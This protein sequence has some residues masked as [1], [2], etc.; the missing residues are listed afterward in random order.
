MLRLQCDSELLSKDL[1]GRCIVITGATSGVG[2]ATALQL[3]KQ[4]AHVVVACR[5]IKLGNALVVRAKAQCRGSAEALL[6]DVSSLESVRSFAAALKER[7]AIVHC[8]VNNAGVMK[9]PLGKTVDGFEVHIGT[10][11][12]G[13][14]L[15]TALLL[16]L[17][18][19]SG[20][21]RVV[22]VSSANH[23]VFA[24]QRGHIDLDDLHYERRK[25]N[26][27]AG[28]AQSKLAQ[29]L[30][31]R[32][33][34][35]RRPSIT[36]VSL[37]P[38]SICTNVTRHMMS[39]TMRR[40]ILPLERVLVGQVSER[41]GIQTGLHCILSDKERLK[42]GAY[43]SQN[44]SPWG[45]KGG[46]PVTSG[47]PEASDDELSHKLWLLSASLVGLPVDFA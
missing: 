19:K 17:L 30:H 5:N 27:W 37:H 6:C 21:G 8:L 34:A 10:N 29:V 38:G 1:T 12:L 20:E 13:P 26:G 39:F 43:Y 41:V 44:R 40:A 33:L 15:L 35:K 18:E 28:Y 45:V 11:Y 47:N 4:G 7:H 3:V 46:W 16:P 25:Y 2:K 32:E 24:G 9:C 36:S 42:S 14:F 23:D 31:A 22:N